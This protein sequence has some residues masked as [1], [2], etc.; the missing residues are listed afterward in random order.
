MMNRMVEKHKNGQL[1]MMA[2][3]CLCFGLMIFS[4]AKQGFRE[5]EA[6]GGPF[7]F[8]SPIAIWECK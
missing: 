3:A 6:N 8:I 7:Y 2:I 5:I 4:C 1:P